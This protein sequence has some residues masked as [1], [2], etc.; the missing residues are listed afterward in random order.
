MKNA[1]KV[2]YTVGKVFNI[3]GIV[4]TALAVVF[5]LFMIFDNVNLYNTLVEDGLTDVPN[6]LALKHVGIVVLFALIISLAYEITALVLVTKA[7][8]MVKAN[9]HSNTP[10]IIMIVLGALGSLCY[11]IGGIFGLISLTTSAPQQQKQ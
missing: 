9:E 10:H 5:S 2:L 1:S 11:L 6:A 8:K 7:Q 4:A 3:I